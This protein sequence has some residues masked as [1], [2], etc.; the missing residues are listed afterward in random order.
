[1]LVC[2]NLVDMWRGY[3][4]VIANTSYLTTHWTAESNLE[5]RDSD[6]MNMDQYSRVV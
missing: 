1:M 4:E 2:Q 3:V 6:W 5:G